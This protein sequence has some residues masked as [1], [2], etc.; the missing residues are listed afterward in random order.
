MKRIVIIAGLVALAFVAFTWWQ[1]PAQHPGHEHAGQ[2]H[3]G[4]ATP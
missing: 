2:G 4:T 1:R 3:A